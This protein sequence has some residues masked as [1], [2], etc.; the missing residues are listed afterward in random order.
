AAQASTSGSISTCGDSKANWYVAS[1]SAS[2]SL[3]SRSRTA[4]HV[5]VAL[6]G[7]GELA[8]G[9]VERDGVHLGA[10]EGRVGRGHWRVRIEPKL[11]PA[12]ALPAAAPWHQAQ[13]V[14]TDR[15]RLLIA[16][17][18]DAGDAV[19]HPTPPRRCDGSAWLR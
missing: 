4:S 14:V 7:H 13:L 9:L 15:G 12:C 8:M 17:R 1:T 16:V 3:R 5:D 2:R 6:G 18:G 10:Q 19:G 11:R